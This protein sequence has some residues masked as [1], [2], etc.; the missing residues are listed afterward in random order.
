MN[1]LFDNDDMIFMKILSGT[2]VAICSF[3]FFV[4]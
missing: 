2:T 3:V 1:N 4:L